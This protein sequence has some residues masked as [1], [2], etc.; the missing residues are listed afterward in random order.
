MSATTIVM[1][2]EGFYYAVDRLIPISSSESMQAASVVFA[3][4]TWRT[5]AQHAHCKHPLTDNIQLHP[6]QIV[7]AAVLALEEIDILK[8][9]QFSEGD[10]LRMRAEHASRMTRDIVTLFTQLAILIEQDLFVD[11]YPEP[12]IDIPDFG[13][14]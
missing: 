7:S 12:E 8:A 6:G 13:G 9:L 1:N 11:E 5:L 3:A 14:F 10:I 2:S 4:G